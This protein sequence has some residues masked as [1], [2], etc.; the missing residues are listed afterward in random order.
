MTAWDRR[1]SAASVEAGRVGVRVTADGAG[2]DRAPSRANPRLFIAIPLPEDARRGVEQVVDAVR[3]DLQDILAKPSG[4]VEAGRR[5]R[6]TGSGVRWVRMDGLHLTLR[7]LG[8]TA[9][10][11][12]GEVS[13][14]VEAVAATTAP[15][16]VV[17]TGA[18][19]FPSVSRPRTLWIGVAQGKPELADVSRQIETRVEALGF[20]RDERPF[21]SHLTL[22]RADGRY[23]GPAAARM[24]REHARTFRAAFQADRIVVFESVTGGGPARYVRLHEA[25]FGAR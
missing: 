7:F 13:T 6:G 14:L 22:A 19:A 16:D 20:P 5:D 11:R 21:R 8:S 24:L 23:E 12:L 17:L 3:A 10:D 4:E 9:A 15:F 2:A 25:R 1:S 18:G